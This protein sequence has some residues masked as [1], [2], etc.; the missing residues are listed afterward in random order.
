MMGVIEEMER[1]WV[2]KK[3]AES[4]RKNTDRQIVEST[5]GHFILCAP[6]VDVEQ[7]TMDTI[8]KCRSWFYLKALDWRKGKNSVH[9]I[10]NYSGLNAN[11][12]NMFNT[13]VSINLI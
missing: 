3:E 6:C 12:V 5:Q 4:E 9:N 10:P 7:V 13:S 1:D 2:Y 8:S 11:T